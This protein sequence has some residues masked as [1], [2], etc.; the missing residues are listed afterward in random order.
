M[1]SHQRSDRFHVMN[2]AKVSQLDAASN[3]TSNSIQGSSSFT[4]RSAEKGSMLIVITKSTWISTKVYV[5]FVMFVPN[6]S[7]LRSLEMLIWR[8]S[9]LDHSRQVWFVYAKLTFH[10]IL[11]SFILAGLM[12]MESIRSIWISTKICDLS[13]ISAQSSS[14][15]SIVGNSTWN[16][17]F[18]INR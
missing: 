14:F 12:L 9:I 3:S 13:V 15:L 2:V 4:A 18:H 1:E 7:L 11:I 16:P 8:G 10:V 17:T 5:L 6:S